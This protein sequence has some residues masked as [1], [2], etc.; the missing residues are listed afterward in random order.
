MITAVIIDDEKKCISLLRHLVERHCTDI[1]IVAEAENAVEGIE[2]IQ[3]HNPGLVFLDIEMPDKTG[4][5]LL[6]SLPD[7]HFDIIF[8][9]AYNHYAIKA[10][11]FSA[12]DYLLK[13]VDI[14]ELKNAVARVYRKHLKKERQESIDLLMNNVRAP[15]T[16]FSRISLSTQDGLVIL[17]VNEILYCEASGTYTIFYLKNKEKIIV[18]KTLKEYEELLKDHHFFRAH[19]SFLVNLNEVKK[20]IKGDGG[21]VIMSNGEEVF[22]SKRRKEEFLA[23]LNKT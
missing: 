5:E 22:V 21:S 23:V 8:T 12:L 4:F 1:S 19:N 20:Y 6:N 17:H 9:T 7:I 16:G 2:A 18:S 13:P 11:R 3:K 10:I 14:D 15:Q